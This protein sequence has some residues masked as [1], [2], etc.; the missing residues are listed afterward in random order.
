ME[1]FCVGVA[2]FVGDDCVSARAK[3]AVKVKTSAAMMDRFI[4]FYGRKG[5]AKA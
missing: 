3:L 1:E 2:E 5:L 4:L